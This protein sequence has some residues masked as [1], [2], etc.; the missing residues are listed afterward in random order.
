MIARVL[1][2]LIVILCQVIGLIALQEL[3]YDVV[4]WEGDLYGT[5]DHLKSFS[6]DVLANDA[7]KLHAL[8]ALYLILYSD[9]V[10]AVKLHEKAKSLSP[11]TVPPLAALYLE[12]KACGGLG[13]LFYVTAVIIKQMSQSEID[14]Q[15]W[16]E[17]LKQ[18]ITLTS[19]SG[20]TQAAERHITTAIELDPND[21]SLR[22][23]A[24]L[25]TPGVLSSFD[26]LT[27]TRARL[28]E[29][30]SHL[31]QNRDSLTLS[32]LD[33][34]S[35]SPT[36]Y[37]VYQGYEDKSLLQSLH[38][39]YSVAHPALM[40]ASS[41]PPLSPSAAVTSRG[42]E[43]K[44]RIGFVSSFF[45]RHSICKLFCGLIIG[46]SLYYILPLHVANVTCFL[47]E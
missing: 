1:L 28:V 14:H 33:E 2:S 32:K 40:T 30:V 24:A 23:R 20:L 19:D 46:V 27:A 16:R 15:Q 45:R 3:D 6:V 35:L 34:F 18:L 38:V 9:I 13:D 17:S 37:Y 44:V 7:K 11:S 25:L 12:G 4:C 5:F 36:F 21:T 22:F 43:S 39:S 29:R 31:Q 47:I 8:S 42:A 26:Q 10:E 41:L